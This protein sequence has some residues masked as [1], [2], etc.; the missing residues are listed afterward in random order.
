MLNAALLRCL[1][2]LSPLVCL[3]A[4]EAANPPQHPP[5]PSLAACTAFRCKIISS[6]SV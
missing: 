1:S 6:A 2:P 3:L 5:G 4:P